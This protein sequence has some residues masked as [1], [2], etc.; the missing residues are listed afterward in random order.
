RLRQTAGFLAS[1]GPSTGFP[2]IKS[3][4]RPIFTAVLFPKD[5]SS[6]GRET[7]HLRLIFSMNKS[8]ASRRNPS[9]TTGPWAVKSMYGRAAGSNFGHFGSDPPLGSPVL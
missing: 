2:H 3:G 4:G 9:C 1:A 5:Q 8:Q 7:F 6:L